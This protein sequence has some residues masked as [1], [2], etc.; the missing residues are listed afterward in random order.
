[1]IKRLSVVRSRVRGGAEIDAAR[2]VRLLAVSDEPEPAFDYEINREAIKPIDGIVGAGDLKPEY[3]DFLANAFSVPLLYVLGN[4]DRGGG[5]QEEKYHVPEPMDGAWHEM[6]GLR[7]CGLSWPTDKDE[8]AI[9]DEN[10]AWRQV[11]AGFLRLRGRHADVV[12]SHVPPFGLGDTPEDHYHRG[13]AAYRWLCERLN[14]A[15]WIHGHTNPAAIDTWWLKAGSTT[16]VNATGAVV[17]EL[18]D[19]APDQAEGTTATKST[20]ATAQPEPVE[21][22]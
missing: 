5:W 3:L 4:H 7:I 10:A 1:M 18:S 16:L 15:L 22:R 12:V 13:F 6:G 17:V 21:A 2:P 19:P 9:H 11:A 20:S 14:P 8:R